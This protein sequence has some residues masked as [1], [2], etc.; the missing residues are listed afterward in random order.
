[1]HSIVKYHQLDCTQ[2]S[3][4]IFGLITFVT[5]VALQLLAPTDN[6]RSLLR[7]DLFRFEKL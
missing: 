5:L 7:I 3:K 4:H 2:S 1:M 6:Y